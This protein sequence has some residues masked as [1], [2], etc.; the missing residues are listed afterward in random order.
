[1]TAKDL[2]GSSGGGGERRRAAASGKQEQPLF[3]PISLLIFPLGIVAIRRKHSNDRADR[4]EH[5]PLESKQG[6]TE[7]KD[8]ASARL[9]SKRRRKEKN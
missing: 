9:V 5:S 2:I 4:E 3:S 6:E 7:N 1:L 8:K